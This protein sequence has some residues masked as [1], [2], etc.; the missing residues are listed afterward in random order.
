VNGGIRKE[1]HFVKLVRNT[2]GARLLEAEH[3]DR[4]VMDPRVAFITTS[5]LEDVIRRGTGIRAR[6]TYELM[7]PAGGKT[8]TDDDGWFAGFTNNLLCVVWV[9]FDDNMDL[10][11]EG[12]HSALPIW[13]RFMKQAHDL[14]EFADPGPFEMPEGV[15]S[16][17]V[18]PET[19]ALTTHSCRSCR[20][21]VYIAG[22]QPTA[23]RLAENAAGV[24]TSVAGWTLPREDDA[25]D[26]AGEADGKKK[27][28]FFGRV[29][30]IF[31]GGEKKT[32]AP[33]P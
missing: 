20:K 6:V 22:S 19:Q 24:S 4:E 9:G 17:D 12:A 11:I 1:P 27:S 3:E 26:G 16:V 32:P 15:I 33:R 10:S 21:E 8:G 13:A 5:M 30:G 28:G 18:D 25:S 2:D 29:L 31:G 23:F 7:V 14:P